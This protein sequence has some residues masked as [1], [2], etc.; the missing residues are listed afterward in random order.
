MVMQFTDFNELRNF[1]GKLDHP[2]AFFRLSKVSK[3]RFLVDG[4]EYDATY[5]EK[6]CNS[7]EE[8]TDTKYHKG[9]I[10]MT[11][12]GIKVRVVDL[13]WDENLT[14]WYECQPVDFKCAI[15]REFK[16]EDLCRV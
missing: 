13:G 6:L 4:Q 16:E 8:V 3:D 12:N 15:T 1:V 9:D 2:D 7:K 10:L 14:L 5:V 11:N